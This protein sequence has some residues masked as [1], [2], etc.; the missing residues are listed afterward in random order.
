[1]AV[2][3][4]QQG[5]KVRS[6]EEI[7]LRLNSLPQGYTLTWQQRQGY[8]S[9]V[10]QPP[11]NQK[12]FGGRLTAP[13]ISSSCPNTAK[14]LGSI[15]RLPMLEDKPRNTRLKGRGVNCAPTDLPTPLRLCKPAC[16]VG[17]AGEEVSAAVRTSV[18]APAQDFFL[19]DPD[20]LHAR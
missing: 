11:H 2:K 13:D 5:N 4:I 14:G 17:S 15:R 12:A 19:P 16:A 8:S 10:Q 1:M 7:K 18:V 6:S 20:L 3:I 9:H